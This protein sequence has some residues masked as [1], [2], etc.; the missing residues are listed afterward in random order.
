[1]SLDSAYDSRENRKII[2]N[3]KMI[4]NIKENKRNRKKTKRGPKNIQ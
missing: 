4:P 3:N 2:F 1:M